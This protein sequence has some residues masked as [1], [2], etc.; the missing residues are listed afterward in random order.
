MC[1]LSTI[2]NANQIAVLAEGKI[3]EAGSHDKLIAKG[4]GGAY[5]SLVNLQSKA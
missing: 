3:V 2:R 1:R 4:E 5:W